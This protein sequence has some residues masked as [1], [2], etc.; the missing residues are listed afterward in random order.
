MDD[1]SLLM[2]INEPA[3][4]MVSM[5]KLDEDLHVYTQDALSEMMYRLDW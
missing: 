5:S 4:L 2:H 3:G 1:V